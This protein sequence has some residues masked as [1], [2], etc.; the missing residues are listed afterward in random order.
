MSKQPERNQIWAYVQS[1]GV[2]MMV[3]H[4]DDGVRARP[5][6]GIS[7]P[8]QN[9][10]WFFADR[11]SHT[12]ED[13]SRNPGVCLTFT[14]VKDNVYVTL[15]GQISPVTEKDTITDLWDDEAEAYFQVG[16]DDPRVS[17]LRFEPDTGEFW[18]APSHPIVLAIKFLE[19]KLFGERP[20]VGTKGR[21][22]LP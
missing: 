10:I 19:A 8:E 9:A 11:E 1:I 14:D 5:M 17:L 6:R 21:T 20:A 15:S 4:G 2:C 3:T 7:R 13:A 22:S 12:H 16:P 18:T